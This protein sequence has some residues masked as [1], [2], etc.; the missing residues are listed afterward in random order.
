MFRKFSPNW[1]KRSPYIHDFSE[2]TLKICA[3]VV[4]L[5]VDAAAILIIF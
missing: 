2:K 5:G 1:A 3:L 4:K